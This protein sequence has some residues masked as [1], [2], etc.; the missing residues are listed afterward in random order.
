M[1]VVVEIV[2]GLEYGKVVVGLKDMDES[3]LVFFLKLII[4]I[5]IE[6]DKKV[7]L[8]NKEKVKEIFELC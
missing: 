4:R 5:V 8:E 6:E 2:R 7:Y 1:D 3:E